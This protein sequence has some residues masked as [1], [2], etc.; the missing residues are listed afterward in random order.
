MKR[1]LGA[2]IVS[3]VIGCGAMEEVVD[4]SKVVV[5]KTVDGAIEIRNVGADKLEEL[6]DYG[7]ESYGKVID[8]ADR[9]Y[10]VLRDGS[11]DI[12]LHARDLSYAA[13]LNLKDILTPDDGEDGAD[14]S[15]GE[16]G[17]DGAAGLDGS[18]GAD[19]ADG[20]DGSNGE[21]GLQGEAGLDGDDGEDGRRGRRGEAGADG[22]DGEGCSIETRDPR[23][24]KHDVYL[25]CGDDEVKL[26]RFKIDN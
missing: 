22:E 21:D 8:G 20:S 3:T 13:F 12:I 24:S 7:V 15:N 6:R 9:Q 25:V 4:Y 19:G 18:D 10:I 16:D 26:G 17:S 11:S 1:V 2:L 5:S 23:G 14:G